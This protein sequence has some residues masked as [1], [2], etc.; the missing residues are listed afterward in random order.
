MCVM[1]T[2]EV[3]RNI[4]AA[5]IES[6]VL[7]VYE[8]HLSECHVLALLEVER[9]HHI[10]RE[11][12]VV[13]EG[14]VQGELLPL[15]EARERACRGRCEPLRLAVQ[16]GP[17]A[18]SQCSHLGQLEAGKQVALGRALEVDIY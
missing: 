7:V 14:D 5:S 11:Q 1:P 15:L 8:L 16:V 13:C 3:I 17:E 4:E 9:Y 12:V 10:A 6:G 2:I 18:L